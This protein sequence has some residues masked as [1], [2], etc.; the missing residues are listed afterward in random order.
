[1]HK[2]LRLEYP[3]PIMTKSR[4]QWSEASPSQWPERTAVEIT[5]GMT[6]TEKAQRIN[7]LSTVIQQQQTIIEQGG[8]NILTSLGKVYNAMS[9]WIS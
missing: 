8:N 1:M 4:N 6:S 9:A 3:A 5:M 2:V 7:A